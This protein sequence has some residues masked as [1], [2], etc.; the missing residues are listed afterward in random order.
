MFDDFYYV[1]LVVIGLVLCQPRFI[2]CLCFFILALILIFSVIAK[3]LAG[4]S[5]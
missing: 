3:R 1:D 4:T 5:N 2:D